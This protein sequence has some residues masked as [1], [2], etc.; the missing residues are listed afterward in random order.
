MIAAFII[1]VGSWLLFYPKQSKDQMDMQLKQARLDREKVNM[2][3]TNA[4]RL[5]V[6]RDLKVLDEREEK[7]RQENLILSARVREYE[8]KEGIPFDVD[9][10][11]N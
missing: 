3:I 9:H 2:D 6:L 5:K 8:R 11:R 10:Y 1:V 7:L 4:R